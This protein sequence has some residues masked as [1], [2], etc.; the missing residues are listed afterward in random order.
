MNGSL[1]AYAAHRKAAGLPG[2]TLAAVQKALKN[3]RITR[4]ADGSIDF[5]RADRE[6]LEHSDQSKFRGDYPDDLGGQTGGRVGGQGGHSADDHH[7]GPEPDAGD[8]QADAE[9]DPESYRE[10][11]R[12]REWVRVRREE[13]ALARLKGELAPV[14]EVNAWV[15]GMILRAKEILL[16]IAPELRDRLAQEKDAAKCE[17]LVTA[18][19]QRALNQLAEFKP[20]PE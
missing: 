8:D 6:W 18:E 4:A 7:E 13:L 1:R 5:E 16:R 20:N 15:A 9:H 19:V 11:Q 12:R 14:A 2:A 3:Q 10:A 17:A